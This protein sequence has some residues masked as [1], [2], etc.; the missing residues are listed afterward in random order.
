MKRWKIGRYTLGCRGVDIFFRKGVGGE[1]NSAPDLGLAEINIGLEESWP[2][3]VITILHETLEMVLSDSRLRWRPT[4][5]YSGDNGSYLFLLT[6][7]QF[8]E[9]LARVAHCLAPCLPDA[10]KLYKRLRK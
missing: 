2:D 8:A 1:F 7:E 4:P 3:V 10:H 5:D 6:H 9:S